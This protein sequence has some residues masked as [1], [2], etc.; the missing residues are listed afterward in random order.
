MNR[1]EVRLLHNRTAA[2]GRPYQD[3]DTLDEVWAD[4][5]LAQSPIAAANQ[6]F[7]RY[8]VG[9]EPDF[10]ADPEAVAYQQEHRSFSIGDVLII[11]DPSGDEFV[12]AAEPQGWR[13]VK[14]DLPR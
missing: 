9:H 7:F 8:N 12:L 6:T 1:Y 2:G 4:S 13:E 3:R 10:G 11:A 14:L 5:V